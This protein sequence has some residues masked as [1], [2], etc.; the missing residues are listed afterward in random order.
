MGRSL[1]NVPRFGDPGDIEPQ[2]IELLKRATKEKLQPVY[3]AYTPLL[4][5]GCAGP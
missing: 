1:F 4:K 2:L 3:V 5:S